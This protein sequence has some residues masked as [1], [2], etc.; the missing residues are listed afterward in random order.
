MNLTSR[1]CSHRMEVVSYLFQNHSEQWNPA[2]QWNPTDLI[3]KLKDF[4][5]LIVAHTNYTQTSTLKETVTKTLH[6]LNQICWTLYPNWTQ[7]IIIKIC[8]STKFIVITINFKVIKV[9]HFVCGPSLLQND[10]NQ[11]CG[12][13]GSMLDIETYHILQPITG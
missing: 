8:L 9:K 10:C 6:K 12:S 11:Q 1:F 7:P 4:Y 2:D 5:D 13:T 3:D